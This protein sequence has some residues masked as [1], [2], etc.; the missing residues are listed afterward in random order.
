[1]ASANLSRLNTARRERLWPHA[2]PALTMK[3]DHP[4]FSWSPASCRF[5]R[6]LIFVSAH[7]A[8]FPEP[9]RDEPGYFDLSHVRRCRG[10]VRSRF[11]P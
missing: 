3:E 7:A 1:M 4:A 10:C 2:E 6:Q 8:D 9:A 11:A 5:L